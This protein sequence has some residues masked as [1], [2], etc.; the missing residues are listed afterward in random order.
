MRT[1]THARILFGALLAILALSAACKKPAPQ[2]PP[3]PP[4]PPAAP[5]ASPTVNLQASSTMIQRGE[6][7]TLTW[8]STNATSLSLSPGIGNVP[9][10]GSQRVTPQAS[11]TYTL[12]A[13][14]PGGSADA[15]AHITV[16][17]PP[18]PPAAHEPTLQELF[19]KSVKDA[20]FDYDKA[21]VR[22]DARDALSQTAQFLR[23]YPQLKVV[24]EGHCDERGSTEY[25]LA[26]GDRRAAAAKQFLISLGLSA[27]R[28][29]TV[30]YGK[31]RPFCSASTDECYQQNRR[32]HF[33]M[34]K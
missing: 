4:P 11:I 1:R 33:V 28:M 18:P 10:E 31:E 9:A 22:P 14:G 17:A 13:T 20:F 32:A 3:P 29:E 16:S 2:A 26:L 7:V 15:N 25:N 30:S 23:S 27:D 12:T 5:P 6:S 8:S 21:D 34:G 19:D 24:I